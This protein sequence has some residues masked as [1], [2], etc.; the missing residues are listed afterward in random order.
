MIKF[1]IITPAYNCENYLGTCLDSFLKQTYTNWRAIVVDDGSKDSTPQI[2]DE[3]ASRD[4]R[5]IAIHKQN[6]GEC[7]ARNAALEWVKSNR[8]NDS[9]LCFVDSDDYVDSR[10]CEVLLDVI[11]KN[12]NIDFIRPYNIRVSSH[13]DPY[14]TIPPNNLDFIVLSREKY[15]SRGICGGYIS[16]IV[17][18]E[19]VVIDNS[20]LF[21]ERLRFL[22]D[23]EFNI[24]C[25]SLCSEYL[26]L[27]SPR[28]YYYRENESSVTSRQKDVGKHI[29]G[30]VNSVY[31]YLMDSNSSE[32]AEFFY[33]DYLPSKLAGYLHNKII[34]RNFIDDLKDLNKEIDVH[35]ASITRRVR[36][37]LSAHQLF[38][39]LF[40]K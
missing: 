17:V 3:Y 26:V 9:W 32:V 34:N 24:H 7:S 16:S 37:G 23:Q 8:I 35:K 36:V 25:A 28:Y 31:K 19:K 4:S 27:R 11:T 13:S 40:K 20:I 21:D 12:P 5:I 10:M 15:F 29:V 1:T 33:K 14:P 2:L 38:S 6:G 30:C 39:K 22:G 18:K